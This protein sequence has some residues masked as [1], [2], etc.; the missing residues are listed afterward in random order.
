MNCLAV[1]AGT[2]AVA[3]RTV[4]PASAGSTSTGTALVAYR[5]PSSATV[6]RKM[7]VPGAE[8]VAVVWA[9]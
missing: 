7:Y 9:A 8:N 5:P 2:A 3:G 1:P 4:R 6:T